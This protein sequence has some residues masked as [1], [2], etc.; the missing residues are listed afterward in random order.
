MMIAM[1]GIVEMEDH[2]R[3]LGGGSMMTKCDGSSYLGGR[4]SF[5]RSARCYIIQP[6]EQEF[7]WLPLF[8]WLLMEPGMRPVRC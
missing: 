4:D 1:F 5:Y 2:Q 8:C 7:W 6:D 3:K